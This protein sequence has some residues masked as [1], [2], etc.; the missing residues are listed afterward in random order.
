MNLANV[1]L[2]RYLD[3]EK[4]SPGSVTAQDV[5]EKRSAYD[6][7]ASALEAGA[8]QRRCRRGATCSG[9]TIL[10]SL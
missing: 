2:Q 4:N 8:G 5:D 9:W 6:D 7:A 10:Q 3:A 1:T